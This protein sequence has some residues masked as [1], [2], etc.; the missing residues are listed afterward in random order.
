MPGSG[1]FNALKALNLYF[2]LI[3]V[4]SFAMMGIDKRRSIRHRWRIPERMFILV[5]ISGGS[6]GALLG[7]WIF[8]HKIRNKV[9]AIGL[10][11]M[12]ILQLLLLIAVVTAV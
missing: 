3:N 7:M 5:A 6:I 8:W 10:P 1:R 2:V 11:L 12:L 9:F 4:I